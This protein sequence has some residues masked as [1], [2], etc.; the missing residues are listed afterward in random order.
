[1][2]LG[3]GITFPSWHSLYA[4][5][6]PFNE[7]TRSVAITNSGISVGTIFGYAISA[8]I[9]ASY[10]WEWVFYSFGLLGIIWFF[11]WNKGITSLPED[12]PKIDEKELMLIKTEAPA[13]T[14][15]G[16]LPI[17]NLLTNLPFLAIAVSTFCN[18][19][20]L[21]T[22]LSYLPKFINSPVSMGGL[23]IDL[24]SSVF[25]L[26][27]LIPSIVSVL[28]LITGGF[29]ADSLI[30]SGYK[31]IKVRKTVNTI[32]FFG[33]ASCLFMIPIQ[34]SYMG[35]IGF[36]CATNAFSGI[37]AGG[38][39]VNHADLGPKYTGSLVGISGSIGMLAAIVSPLMA[40]I[41]LDVTGSWTLIF[42]ICTA[43]LVFGGIF[44]LFFA[45]ASEQFK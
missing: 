25:I 22:F 10:S 2:G 38:F 41:I 36:L 19:W 23:G 34:D 28:A 15:A 1:M 40:G 42:H 33:A 7:R 32:G 35:I 30:K 14:T 11:F 17:N 5:W 44:Y 24:G 9:I 20:A 29:M 18:N 27:I 26:I 13:D 8:M 43:V 31:V 4:R 21:F 16:K 45:S 3:E 6:I 39:G 37:G 12:H